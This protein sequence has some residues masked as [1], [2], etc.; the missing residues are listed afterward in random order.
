LPQDVSQVADFKKYAMARARARAGEHG[1]QN[2][3]R[4]AQAALQIYEVEA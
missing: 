1:E 2:D 4:Q 3:D